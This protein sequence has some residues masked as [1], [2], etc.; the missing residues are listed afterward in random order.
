MSSDISFFG[1]LKLCV[2]RCIAGSGRIILK[3][4]QQRE[5]EK[6]YEG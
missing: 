3:L 5:K 2:W 1:A 6:I 4:E